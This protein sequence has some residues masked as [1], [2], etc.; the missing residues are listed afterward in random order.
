MFKLKYKD[1]LC[2]METGKSQLVGLLS[3]LPIF[4]WCRYRLE[5]TR[6]DTAYW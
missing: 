6:G 1:H 2:V 3:R 4:I 5:A